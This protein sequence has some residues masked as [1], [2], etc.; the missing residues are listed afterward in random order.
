[1]GEN[2]HKI[3]PLP[4]EEVRKAIDE[5]FT[6]NLE[7]HGSLSGDS[8]QV[9]DG[10]LTSSFNLGYNNYKHDNNQSATTDYF[11]HE[12]CPSNNPNCT[13][14]LNSISSSSSS[15]R[16][17]QRTDVCLRPVLSETLPQN[18]NGRQPEDE[19]TPVTMLT[20]LSS[21]DNDDDHDG[22]GDDSANQ[23][24]VPRNQNKYEGDPCVSHKQVCSFTARTTLDCV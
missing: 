16:T 19:M 23:I 1:M 17:E 6:D 12:M 3:P 24:L 10:P 9:C 5:I 13:E 15:G 14:E 18:L 4:E 22:D 2:L 20:L 7:Q 21:D 11:D 8:V